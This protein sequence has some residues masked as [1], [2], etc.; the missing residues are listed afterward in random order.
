MLP[1]QQLFLNTIL[2]LMEILKQLNILSGRLNYTEE[3][4]AK[5]WIF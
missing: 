1:N 5:L 2:F 4:N 3:L